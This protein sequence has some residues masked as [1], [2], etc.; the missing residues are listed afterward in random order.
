MGFH[1]VAR[2]CEHRGN[3]LPVVKQPLAF[4]NESFV[5]LLVAATYCSCKLKP[6]FLYGLSRTAFHVQKHWRTFPVPDNELGLWAHIPYLMQSFTDTVR[7]NLVSANAFIS[8]KKQTTSEHDF[9]G[10][11]EVDIVF[12]AVEV[13]DRAELRPTRTYLPAQG[14]TGRKRFTAL[15]RIC[16]ACIHGE[17]PA[18]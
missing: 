8:L 4:M 3:L 9:A 13:A 17:H 7:V 5:P 18:V 6:V 1:L 10:E 12:S 15:Y 14:L 11:Y 16:L 2:L